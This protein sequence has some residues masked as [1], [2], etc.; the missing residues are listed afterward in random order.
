MSG[1]RMSK[2]NVSLTLTVAA[3]VGATGLVVGLRPSKPG[4]PTRLEHH[5]SGTASLDTP[6][7]LLPHWG[8][9]L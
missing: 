3:A 9:A 6:N 4:A 1:I 5:Y 7:R 2:R 8:R